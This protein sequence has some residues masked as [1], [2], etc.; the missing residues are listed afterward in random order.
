MNQEDTN[1]AIRLTLIA[2]NQQTLLRDQRRSK[3]Y[4]RCQLSSSSVSCDTNST[5]AIIAR[6]S[7]FAGL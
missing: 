1:D 4:Y 6:D 3:C 2:T 7:G 5:F